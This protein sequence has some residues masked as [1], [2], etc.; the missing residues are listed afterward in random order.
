MSQHVFKPPFV[1]NFKCIGPQCADSCCTHWHIHVDQPTYEFMLYRSKLKAE[2]A[3][4]FVRTPQ[5]EAYA[6]IKLDAQGH[7]PLLDPEGW[8]RVQQ[9]DGLAHLSDTCRLFPRKALPR[10]ATLTEYTLLLSCPEVVRQLIQAPDLF[11]W[12]RP[13]IPLYRTTRPAILSST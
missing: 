10:G 3:T 4:A 12:T 9:E 5:G 7:C 2:A 11:A 1:E 6:E 8:C 13:P